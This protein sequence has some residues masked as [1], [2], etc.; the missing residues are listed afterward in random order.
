MTNCSHLG[1]TEKQIASNIYGTSRYSGG[2][3]DI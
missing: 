2:V 3:Y 1:H